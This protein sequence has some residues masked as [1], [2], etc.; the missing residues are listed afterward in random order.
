MIRDPHLDSLRSAQTLKLEAEF[1]KQTLHT[2]AMDQILH[3]MH[4]KTLRLPEQV[5]LRRYVE[6]SM[7][8]GHGLDIDYEEFPG[9]IK[10]ENGKVI[11][12]YKL[13]GCSCSLWG[14]G[15]KFLESYQMCGMD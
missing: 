6:F 14:G 15:V 2:I 1:F 11:I 5:A 13:F 4:T 3:S 8:E 12:D 10:I 9:S 7:E